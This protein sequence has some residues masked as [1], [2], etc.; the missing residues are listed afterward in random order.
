[1][2]W[3]LLSLSSS[4]HESTS[5]DLL[6]T[7]KDPDSDA[8]IG[9]ALNG[10]R[11]ALL[12]LVL[13]GSAAQQQQVPLYEVPHSRH[14]VVTAHQCCLCL[15][16]LPLPPALLSSLMAAQQTCQRIHWDSG[17]QPKFDSCGGHQV[18]QQPLEGTL[19]TWVC[20]K[21]CLHANNSSPCL[22]ALLAKIEAVMNSSSETGRDAE[23]EGW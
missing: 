12:Q 15:K 11:D 2:H 6:V 21:P 14:L 8:S 20:N 7:S 10:L 17:V 9:Q 5:A 23:S 1:M 13:N 19:R 4:N 22:R 16:I 18:K 3:R